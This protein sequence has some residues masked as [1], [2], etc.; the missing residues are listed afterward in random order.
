MKK[1]FSIIKLQAVTFNMMPFS[2][3]ILSHRCEK[4]RCIRVQSYQ[5]LDLYRKPDEIQIKFSSNFIAGTEQIVLKHQSYLVPVIFQ[6]Y[7]S[8]YL[9]WNSYSASSNLDSITYFIRQSAISYVRY[10]SVPF[11]PRRQ[12]VFHLQFGFSTIKFGCRNLSKENLIFLLFFNFTHLL[13][14]YHTH[15]CYRNLF[16]FYKIDFPQI[17]DGRRTNYQYFNDV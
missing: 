5:S 2:S 13:E 9:T 14:Y 6:F 4:D 11:Q 17:L 7:F 12:L 8:Y 10:F 16:Q 15:T 3:S 1:R